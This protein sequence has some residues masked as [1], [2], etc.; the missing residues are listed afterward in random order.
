M[1]LFHSACLWRLSATGGLALSM[2]QCARAD[3]VDNYI[4]RRMARE[5]IPGLT[6]VVKRKAKT[7]KGKGSGHASVELNVPA[8]PDT[9]Y[10]LA[11]TTKPFVATAV[12]LLVQDGKLALDDKVT[13]F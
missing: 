11:S 4:E 9:V 12:L 5:H 1:P 8:R 6:L 7:V 3:A 2:V 10:A 13:Q